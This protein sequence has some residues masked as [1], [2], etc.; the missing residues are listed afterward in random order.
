MVAVG[1]VGI[2]SR[3]AWTW[4]GVGVI[5]RVNVGLLRQGLGL[6]PRTDCLPVLGIQQIQIL[7]ESIVGRVAKPR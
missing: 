7:R 6:P 1:G 5:S 4:D 2:G 3:K